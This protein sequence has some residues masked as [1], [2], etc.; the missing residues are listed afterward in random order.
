MYYLTYAISASYSFA[1]QF[2]V[3]HL[4]PEVF[5][6]TPNSDISNEKDWAK[7]Q[8]MT[9]S[10]Y[11]TDS[12]IASMLSGGLNFQ[13]EHHLFPTF[14]HVHY[15][16]KIAPIVQKTCN[17]YNVP[18]NAIPSYWKAISGHYYQLRALGN[19]NSM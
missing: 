8:I 6:L 12:S 9:S 18:Y 19:P 5:W 11:A 14:C 17:E 2:T 4:T 16:S 7:L 15:K 10:N 3:N 1:F 13:I